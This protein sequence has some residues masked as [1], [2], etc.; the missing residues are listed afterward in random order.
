MVVTRL[1]ELHLN[2]AVTMDRDEFLAL[3]CCIFLVRWWIDSYRH[4][5]KYAASYNKNGSGECPDG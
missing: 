5:Y 1:A 4:I 2:T 3:D